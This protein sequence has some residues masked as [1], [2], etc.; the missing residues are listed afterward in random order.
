MKNSFLVK[1]ALL[2]VC[3]LL[4]SLNACT[5]VYAGDLYDRVLKT[6]T[7][8]AA[9][10]EYYPFFMKDP[11]TKKYSGISYDLL[12]LAAKRLGLKLQLTEEVTWGTMIEGLKNN[13]YDTLA[14]P[15]WANS[16]RARAADFS[17]AICFSPICAFTKYGDK[18]IDSSLKGVAEGKYKISCADGEMAEM[19]A[20]ADYPKAP[21]LSLPQMAPLSDMLLNVS[22]GKA[23]ITFAEPVFVDKF[24]KHNPKALQNIT[25]GKPLRVFPNVYMFKAGEQEFKAMLNT[26]LDEIANSG[27]LEKIILKY[28]PYP[29]AFLRC[30]TP[31]QK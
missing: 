28:E 24:A 10:T 27:E 4:A 21:R 23:D 6:G 15:V 2:H 22:T 19:I 7:I 5:N 31:Y 13:R 11:N 12:D 20:K 3:I 1:V 14:S 25:P 17:R 16:Q 18:R 30:A 29:K 26:A 9:Y 8:K